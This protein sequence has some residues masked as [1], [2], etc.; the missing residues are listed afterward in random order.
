MRIIHLKSLFIKP[1]VSGKKKNKKNPVAATAQRVQINKT[2]FNETGKMYM[3][4]C[5]NVQSEAKQCNL[6]QE[7][8]T[9]VC[10][11]AHSFH[12][13]DAVGYTCVRCRGAERRS[14]PNVIAV[15]HRIICEFSRMLM[16]LLIGDT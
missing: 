3:Q 7:T 8:T 2:G 12:C 14:R 4:K 6:S 16:N 13:G 15:W 11:G 5:G 9:A 10:N 1:T